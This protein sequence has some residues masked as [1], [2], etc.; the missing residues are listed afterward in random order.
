MERKT[1]TTT[2]KALMLIGQ[3]RLFSL[4]VFFTIAFCEQP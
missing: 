3:K 4:N 1:T 2:T